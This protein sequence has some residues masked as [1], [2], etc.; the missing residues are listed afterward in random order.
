MRACRLTVSSANIDVKSETVGL[1]GTWKR[2]SQ[3]QLD[4]VS[5][6]ARRH[7]RRT[8]PRTEWKIQSS[9]WN[10]VGLMDSDISIVVVARLWMNE[11]DVERGEKQDE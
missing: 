2:P 4:P 11:D 10:P 3:D 9:I 6:N 1:A 8:D 7:T 5:E